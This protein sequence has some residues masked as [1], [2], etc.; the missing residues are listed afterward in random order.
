MV[1]S[2]TTIEYQEKHEYKIDK[3]K[4]QTSSSPVGFEEGD[5]VEKT[6]ITTRNELTQPQK[7][8]RI[9]RKESRQLK[10]Y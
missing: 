4:I 10:S 8:E 5:T 7:L 6:H 9:R 2:N 1:T 3:C